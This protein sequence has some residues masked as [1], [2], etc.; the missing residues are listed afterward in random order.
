MRRTA[1]AVLLSS[2]LPALPAC[3]GNDS[4]SAGSAIDASHVH[5]LGL[6]PGEPDRVLVA[7]QDG[8]AAYAVGPDL[9]RVSELSS[10]LMGFAVGP[11]GTLY[12]SGHPGEDEDGP[13]ALGLIASRDDGQT[14]EPVG[15]SGVADFHALDAH[16]GGI[17]GF[18]AANGVL[19][20]SRDG[21]EADGGASFEPVDGAP[22]VVLVDYS[23][24]GD[25]VGID[26]QGRLQG[27]DDS[28]GW[29]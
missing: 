25:L 2:L 15:L 3:G 9:Q 23:S 11:A 26:T 28:G 8:L 21:E 24:E 1:T 4:A 14:W 22:P 13:F 29:E 19:R 10:D 7:T 5:G 16:E 18:D 27:R 6:A 20:T 17:Y 12:A